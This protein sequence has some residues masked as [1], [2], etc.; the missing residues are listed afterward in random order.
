MAINQS[1]PDTPLAATPEPRFVQD[2][3]KPKTWQQMSITEK[4][5]KKK[6]LIKSGGMERFIKYKDSISAEATNK[7]EVAFNKAAANAGM[8]TKEYSKFLEKRSKMPD[9]G[10]DGLQGIGNKKNNNP[11]PCKGGV[12]TGVNKK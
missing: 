8:S 6:E 5:N 4:G 9:V 10:L 2:T 11:P 7:R 3:I 12:C 1:R